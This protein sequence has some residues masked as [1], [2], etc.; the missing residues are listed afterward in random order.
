MITNKKEEQEQNEI[1]CKEQKLERVT[2]FEYLES[3]II[4]VEKIDQK[5]VNRKRKATRKSTTQ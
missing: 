2:A 5:I 1:R 3:I 4:K